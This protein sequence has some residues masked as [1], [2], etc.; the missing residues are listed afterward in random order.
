[1]G[2]SENLKNARKNKNLSQEQLAELLNVSR[3]SVSKWEQDNGYPETEKLMQVAQILD[4]S[5]DSLLLD[6]QSAM[7]DNTHQANAN[8]AAIV[9]KEGKIAIQSFDGQTLSNYY[10]FTIVKYSKKSLPRC[11]LCGI[12]SSSFLGDNMVALGYYATIEDAQK[13]ITEIKNAIRDGEKTYTLKY[14]A[15]VEVKA[16]RVKMIED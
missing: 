2:F 1:M 3:Q 7:D 6:K 8:D 9:S 14:H 16:L 4:V 15:E 10:K 13:E 12:D 11:A 5:L